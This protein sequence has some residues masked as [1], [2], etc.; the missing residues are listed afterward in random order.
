MSFD[1]DRGVLAF[2]ALLSVLDLGVPFVPQEKGTCGAASL[3][4]VLAY[5]GYPIPHEQIAAEL[6]QPD[7]KDISGQRLGAFAHERR[8]DAIVYEGDLLQLRDFLR[9]GRPQI[10]AWKVGR[11][12]HEVVVVGFDDDRNEVLV[13]DPAEGT[14]LRVHAETFERRWAGAGHWTLLVLPS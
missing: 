11:T 3:A 14:A 4:M 1:T 10:V 7:L 6:G 13:N 2:V 5:W 8:L 12:H 9:R